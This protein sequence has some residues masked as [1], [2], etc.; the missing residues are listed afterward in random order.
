MFWA[1]KLNYR[2]IT[3]LLV[4][5]GANLNHRIINVSSF[6]V[7]V[8]VLKKIERYKFINSL[9]F[10]IVK[11]VY[12]YMLKKKVKELEFVKEN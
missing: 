2:K 9:M 3:E 6:H 8:N 10:I 5:H 12:A 1:A 11:L 7:H 4:E